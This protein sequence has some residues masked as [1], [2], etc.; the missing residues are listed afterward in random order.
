MATYTTNVITADVKGIVGSPNEL[1]ASLSEA[2]VGVSIDDRV[3]EVVHNGSPF[4]QWIDGS[5]LL[6]THGDTTYSWK[7]F[8][9]VR[10][11]RTG[12]LHANE[13]TFS[14]VL[15]GRWHAWHPPVH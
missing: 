11:S 8:S 13:Q 10:T 9:L 3:P 5:N 2:V 6:V 12:Q 14:P 15:L 4:K 7:T 1:R